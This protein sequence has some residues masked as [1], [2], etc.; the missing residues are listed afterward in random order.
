M[1]IFNTSLEHFQNISSTSPAFFSPNKNPQVNFD[2]A[3]SEVKL[4][5]A[6]STDWPT[7]EGF[8]NCSVDNGMTSDAASA[9]L[10]VIIHKPI[11]G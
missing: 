3:K 1:H 6:N 2:K 5:V 4:T 11:N 10:T 7:H 9:Y 8:Y